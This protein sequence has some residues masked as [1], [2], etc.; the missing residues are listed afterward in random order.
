M[1]MQRIVEIAGSIPSLVVVTL[2]MLVLKPGVGTIILAL[3]IAL[4]QEHT[5]F[6][7]RI[8][9]TFLQPGLRA[10]ESSL[11]STRKY[12]RTFSARF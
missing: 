8:R 9:N 3:M 6:E 11:S 7:S 2:L 10:R 5:R 4:L 1:I 12:S